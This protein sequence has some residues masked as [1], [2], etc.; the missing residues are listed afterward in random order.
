MRLFFR[1]KTR[2]HSIITHNISAVAAK[3][4]GGI[5]TGNWFE[6]NNGQIYK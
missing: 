3:I 4:K 6:E 1:N 5:Q 2:Q